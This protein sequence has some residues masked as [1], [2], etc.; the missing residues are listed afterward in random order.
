MSNPCLV[1]TVAVVMPHRGMASDDHPLRFA[2]ELLQ[3]KEVTPSAWLMDPKY[4][5]A[6]PGTQKAVEI[7]RLQGHYVGMR[8]RREIVGSGSLSSSSSSAVC[9]VTPTT[10]PGTLLLA[11]G[12][13]G[14]GESREKKTERVMKARH[15]MLDC[16]VF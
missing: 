6:E 15:E 2:R 4:L 12:S 8:R 14:K 13:M 3:P 1:A 9:E 11:G 5:N 7:E 10:K 16:R